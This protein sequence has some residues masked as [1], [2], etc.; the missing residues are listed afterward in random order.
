MFGITQGTKLMINQD[1]IKDHLQT[2]SFTDHDD[3]WLE[4]Y[5]DLSCAV[6]G[7]SGALMDSENGNLIDEHDVIIRCNQTPLAGYEKHVGSRTDIRIMNS[8]FFTSL[9]DL[10][11][12]EGSHH[13]KHMRSIL[14]GFDP[15]YLYSLSDETVVVKFGVFEDAFKGEIEKIESKNN[16]VVF[17]DHAFYR[18]GNSSLGGIH[19]TN[20]YI[21]IL[22][23]MKFFKS[24]S[25]FGFGFY[26]ENN[27]KIHYYEEVNNHLETTP[28]HDNS[29]EEKNG[30]N[31][32]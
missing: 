15:A 22:M 5:K 14:T 21:A 1:V 30:F 17:M 20:G 9:K 8:H 19:S 25:C 32:Y 18:M 3:L 31:F 2:T 28:C 24:V 6:V 7:N 11:N 29:L 4:T 23:A 10:G 13:I 27:D 16:K 12:I 26:K